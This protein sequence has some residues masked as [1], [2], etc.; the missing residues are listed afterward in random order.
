MKNK[1]NL[2]YFLAVFLFI[3]Q[4]GISQQ[5][6]FSKIYDFGT[7]STLFSIQQ[8]SDSGYIASGFINKNYEDAY[9]IKL[10]KFGDT[11]WTKSYGYSY[12]DW[13]HDIQIT[14]D[15]GYIVAGRKNYHTDMVDGYMYGDVWILKLDANGDT[16]WTKTFGGSYCDYANSIK[17]TS[18]GGYIVAGTKNNYKINYLGDIWILK[19]DQNGDTLWTKTFHFSNYVSEAN[20]I[21]QTTGGN[22]LVVGSAALGMPSYAKILAMK[23]QNNGDTLW[24]KKLEG[25]IGNDLAQDDNSNILIVGRDGLKNKLIKLLSNGDFIWE[26]SYLTAQNYIFES[27]SVLLNSDGNIISTGYKENVNN[28][29]YYMWIENNNC[30]NGDTIWTKTYNFSL[31]D[32]AY[33]IKKTNDNGY[34]ISGTTNYYAWLL[35]LNGNG[36]TLSN[37]QENINNSYNSW[38][39][40]NPFNNST[41]IFFQIPEKECGKIEINIYNSV[42]NIVKT[43]IQNKPE[44]NHVF[45]E[46]NNLPSGVY[47]YKICTQNISICKKMILIR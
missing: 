22:Y 37:V 16:L 42:G 14:S 23:L 10:N 21:I 15:G 44:E 36:D 1:S 45:F 19:L 13:A 20:S 35:K 30:L 41:S 39:Y 6:T 34:I 31:R 40:P 9:I 46:T 28:G 33:S 4:S 38:N 24:C 18:D 17:Q 25:Y 5:I 26:N 11:L 8:T 27:T 32:I 12:R 47:F 7:N 29:E 2:F 43:I 3:T